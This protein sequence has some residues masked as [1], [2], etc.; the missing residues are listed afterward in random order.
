[1][2]NLLFLLSFLFL[3][4]SCSDGNSTTPGGEEEGEE[5]G[6]ET[7]AP[8]VISLKVKQE[9]ANIFDAMEFYLVPDRDC[10]LQDVVEAYDSI[11]WRVKDNKGTLKLLEQTTYSVIE[12]SFTYSWSHNF[13]NE[14]S[15]HTIMDGYKDGKI[16]RSDTTI[17][18]TENKRDFL[19]YDWKDITSSSKGLEGNANALESEYEISFNKKY[20]DE[21]PS[22]YV[23]FS[24][25]HKTKEEE[26]KKFY[27]EKQEKLMLDYI[28]GLYGSPK[29]SFDKNPATI[30]EDYHSIFQK[31]DDSYTPRYIW[32]TETSNIALVKE[33][34]EWG[35]HYECY[36]Y[37]EPKLD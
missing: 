15:Y 24:A 12:T 11:L 8:V 37:A 34:N 31:E 30:Q 22:L 6:K 32:Q 2:K 4:Y 10:S 19:Y 33:Y 25:F 7:P 5:P 16:I 21:F 17:V 28:S 36:I 35:E 20:I 26:A 3:A 18:V 23:H 14:G 13:H 9:K 27:N 29:F 1:M